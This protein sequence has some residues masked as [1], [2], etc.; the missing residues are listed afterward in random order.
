MWSITSLTEGSLVVFWGN[1]LWIWL[2]VDQV[3]TFGTVLQ[4]MITNL[5][6]LGLILIVFKGGL[7]ANVA[8]LR[9]ART[10]FCLSWLH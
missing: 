7:A 10:R 2:P 8:A 1:S 6:Y 5:G 9:S 3:Q 4:Q